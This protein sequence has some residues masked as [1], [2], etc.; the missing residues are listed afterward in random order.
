MSSLK[1]RLVNFNWFL[2]AALILAWVAALPLLEPHALL[3]T[4]GGG[5]SP[6]LLQRTHQLLAALRQGQ[7]P[8]RVMPDAYYGYSYPFFN[9]YAPLSIYIAAGFKLL[10]FSFTR[11][12]QLAQLA[13]FLMA[14]WAMFALAL[15]VVG[16]RWG[17]LLAS[18]AYTFAPFH[19]VNVYVRG[20][21]LAEFWAMAFYPL[22]LLAADD[23]LR[24][25][26]VVRWRGRGVLKLGI[27]YAGLVLSHNISA[28]IFS[29][30]LAG[31]CLLG[32]KRRP[33]V[34]AQGRQIIDD[35]PQTE[36][37]SSVRGLSSVVRCLFQLSLAALLGLALSAWFWL[38]ALLEQDLVQLEPVTEGFFNY[39]VN[40]RGADLVQRSWLFDYVVTA[41]QDP[42]RMGLMQ[43]VLI[44]IGVIGLLA[45]WIR[46]R[47]EGRHA[48]F[49]LGT[50][51]VATFMILPQSVGMWDRLPLL[52]FTQF[53]WRFL[54]VQVLGGSLLVGFLV[55]G[56]SPHPQHPWR[57][58]QERGALLCLL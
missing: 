5:D 53:P 44:G 10:G 21:S 15:R 7:F 33:F 28:L 16:N 30:F 13:G 23:L 37:L 1:H 36:A 25:C 19:M 41:E 50:V 8:V 4:R 32:I 27:A 40:F 38:P 34:S 39:A 45:N 49:V 12:I 6:F 14:A 20:D 56:R 58:G 57:G 11:A 55:W 2:L 54:S 26:G 17:A 43:T 47:V 51:L 9:F 42:F 48:I 24:D 29:P 22:T 3:N 52:E 35:R 18:V 31:F 46:G